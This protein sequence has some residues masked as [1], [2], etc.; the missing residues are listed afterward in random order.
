MA[1]TQLFGARVKRVE[2]PRFLRG[3]ATYVDDIRLPGTLHLA[4]VRSTQ[5]HAKIIRIDVSAARQARGVHGVYTGAD[6]VDALKPLGKPYNPKIF[7]PTMARQCKWPCLAVGKVRHVGEPVVAVVAESRYLAEDAAE[8]VEIDYE[9][10][11]VL[12]DAEEA[13]KP[14]APL[15][16]EEFD[17]NVM[18]QLA[19][20][21]GE[22][23]AAFRDASVVIRERFHTNRHS[24][25]AMEGRATL[26]KCDAGGEITLWSANQMPHMLRT[27]VADSMGFPE[28]KIRVI[29]PDVGGGFGPKAY[30]YPEDVLVCHFARLLQRP[31]RWT[32]DRR[33]HLLATG[34]AKEQIIDCEMAFAADGTVLGMRAKIVSDLGAYSGDPWP[35]PFEGLQLAMALP[36]PYKMK[37]YAYDVAT[38]WTNKMAAVAYRGVGLTAAVY[39]QEHMMDLAARRLGIDP[40][41]LRMKN[42]IRPE[43]FPYVTLSGLHYDSSSSTEALK[44]AVEKFGYEDFRKRQLEARARG[45]YVGVGFS[46]YIEMTTF[47]SKFMN[48]AGIEHHWHEAAH[49][50]M[51][52]NGG[53]I[54]TVGTLSHG[55]GHQTTFA[56]LAA[57][58]LGIR[59]ED[60]KLVQGDTDATP[61]GGG[62]GGSRSA[63]AGGG[64]IIQAARKIREKMLRIAGKILEVSPEDLELGAGMVNVKGV[65]TRAIA[66]KD[67][68]RMCVLSTVHL[69]E[70]EEPGLEGSQLYDPPTPFANAT[71]V[72][73]V[74]VDIET[75]KTQILRYVVIEDCGKMINPM[76]VEGQITGG[77]AQGIG[78][79]L[80]EHLIYDE[81]GQLQTASLM[82]YLMPASTDVPE[83][84]FGHMETL[85]PLSVGGI[86]G[87]GEGGAIAPP[88]ALANAIADALS[89]FNVKFT[90]LPLT[91]T[92]VWEA[93]RNARATAT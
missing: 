84:E 42:L 65:P 47:G 12:T 38:V 60:V 11:P 79:A 44:M 54:L 59:V 87:M 15:L 2:D 25:S 53:A 71:H 34:H 45:K 55:Q 51:D 61:Y 9:D 16:H 50:R 56:Q 64:A 75:G 40:V 31:V 70:G 1:M 33:E 4:L 10:L 74:E 14:G 19:G 3:T 18:L 32:E 83:V 81:I 89:P 17:T 41:E 5:A 52:P 67:I 49:I 20:S 13:M 7:P 76:I 92:R 85:S 80:Y 86:K 69:P 48:A 68:T 78:T 37:G 90:E 46:T 82:D 93:I 62:T 28:Q 88:G 30:V 29:V 6:V 72:A 66:V 39:V 58:E 43:E 23:D 63:V 35:G 36:G 26:A 73:E 77:V 21:A 24:G 57:D 27:R 22:V 91:P 8:L